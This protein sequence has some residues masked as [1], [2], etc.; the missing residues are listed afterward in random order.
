MGFSLTF[1]FSCLRHSSSAVNSEALRQRTSQAEVLVE[2]HTACLLVVILA[3]RSTIMYS[4]RE[5][6]STSAC[7]CKGKLGSDQRGSE[8]EE[9]KGPK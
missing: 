4:S 6:V 2:M 9:S 1:L 3:W 5:F 8:L 7:C